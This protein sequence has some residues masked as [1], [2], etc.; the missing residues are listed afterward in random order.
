[1]INKVI[2]KSKP[3]WKTGFCSWDFCPDFFGH[4]GKR[5]WEI[6]GKQI[7]KT[8]TM[9]NIQLHNENNKSNKVKAYNKV[10]KNQ[11][12]YSSCCIL[13]R[14]QIS[15]SA[16]QTQ[17]TTLS[18]R[19]TIGCINVVSSLERKDLLMSVDNVVAPL[20]S[21]VV[22]T[23]WQRS[24]NIVTTSEAG[25]VQCIFLKLCQLHFGKIFCTPW[26]TTFMGRMNT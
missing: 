3:G 14:D 24:A 23:L 6:N 19:Q 13:L 20:R 10:Q 21:N 16:Q 22:A 9:P 1:M 12:K 5:Q 2:L 7:I 11:K 4:V 26:K 15:L 8:H 25:S 18:K 17:R